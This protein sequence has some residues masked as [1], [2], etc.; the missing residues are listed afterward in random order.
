MLKFGG[1]LQTGEASTAA[2]GVRGGVP[3]AMPTGVSRPRDSGD[4]V[5]LTKGGFNIKSAGMLKSG[6]DTH[7]DKKSPGRPQRACP[8]MDWDYVGGRTVGRTA[9]NN[10]GQL[11]LT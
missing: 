7:P 8:D 3:T 2:G 9:L 1:V 4:R 6:W 11:G 10:D 5:G